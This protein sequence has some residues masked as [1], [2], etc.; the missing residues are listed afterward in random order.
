MREELIKAQ[1][2]ELD[3]PEEDKAEDAGEMA[4]GDEETEEEM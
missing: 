2:E 1:D 4:E 3:A